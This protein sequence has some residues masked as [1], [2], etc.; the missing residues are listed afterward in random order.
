MT[1]LTTA[2]R[3]VLLEPC[4]CGHDINDHGSMATCWTCS[5]EGADDCAHHFEELLCERVG[6]IVAARVASESTPVPKSPEN[7]LTT[8]E[9]HADW[10]PRP[11]TTSE[12]SDDE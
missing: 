11:T 8:T 3:A 6:R 5:D 10:E 12:E 9:H 1:S 2:E 7:A 4:D